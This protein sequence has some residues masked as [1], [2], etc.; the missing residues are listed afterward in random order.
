MPLKPRYFLPGVPEHIVQ[1]GSNRQAT[2]FDDSDC[3]AYM[4]SLGKA[5][6]RYDCLLPTYVLMTN[7]VHLLIIPVK[8]D[9]VSRV[10]QYVG[11]RYVPYVNPVM[12]EKI[13]N[14]AE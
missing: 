7:H 14:G 4:K 2:F 3:H 10:M 1:R 6:L 13:V 11:R 5:L 8:D 12:C 9:S